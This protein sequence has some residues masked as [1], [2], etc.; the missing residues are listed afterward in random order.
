MVPRRISIRIINPTPFHAISRVSA[1]PAKAH[2]CPNAL[3]RTEI[4]PYSELLYLP[5]VKCATAVE[6]FPPPSV[7][8]IPFFSGKSGWNGVIKGNPKKYYTSFL[9]HSQEVETVSAKGTKTEVPCLFSVQKTQP[10]N[11]PAGNLRAGASCS[12][13]QQRLIRRK[14]HALISRFSI[15]PYTHRT[16]PQNRIPSHTG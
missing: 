6:D 10:K 8:E 16:T 3:R 4:M 11:A 15:N 1:S 5:G 13:L 9:P 7:G 2:G 12:G 14:Y